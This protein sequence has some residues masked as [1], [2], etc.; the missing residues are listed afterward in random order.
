MCLLWPYLFFTTR[1]AGLF[2]ARFRSQ[3]TFERD[4]RDLFRTCSSVKI[5]FAGTQRDSQLITA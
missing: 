4:F 1:S 3:Q 5:H 2:G